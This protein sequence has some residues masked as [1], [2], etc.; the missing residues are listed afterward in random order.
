MEYKFKYSCAPVGK[1]KAIQFEVAS[2]EYIKNISVTQ[3]IEFGGKEI[4][5][6][7]TFVD[8]IDPATGKPNLGAINDPRMGNT[9]DL[10]HPGYFGHIEL[11]RPVYHIG[12]MKVV[13]DILRSVSY[14]TS[15]L[16][17]N[18]DVKRNRK[19]FNDIN[20]ILKTIK[21]CPITQNK[22]PVYSREGTKILADFGSGKQNI[23]TLEIYSILEKISD[24]DVKYL[25]LKTRPEYFLLTV[26]PVPPP[27]VRPSVYMNSSQKCDD[28]L[29]SNLNDIIK[30]NIALKTAT[31]KEENLEN[32][33]SNLEFLLQ[34]NINTLIDN[35]HPGQLPKLQRSGKPLKTI[36]ERLSGKD[37][38]V[39]GNLMGK[40]V[41][42]SARTVIT[43]DPNLSI[44]QVG[45]PY[46]IAINLTVPEI[47]NV[48]NKTRLQ[49]YVN[50]GPLT[51]PGAK[52]VTKDNGVKVDLKFAKNVD[53][54]LGWVIERHLMDNDYVIFN[55]QPSLH[56]MSIMGHKVK[57]LPGS[58]FRLNL[59]CT[60]PYNAD[61]D[62]DEMNL[63]VPQSLAAIAEVKHLMMVDKQIVSPQS[64]KP[65]ISIIQD[66]LLSSCKMTRR[67]VLITKDHL[68]NMLILIDNWDNVIPTP[69]IIMN[70]VEYWTGKQVYSIL[71]PK[72]L[73][74][75]N[76]KDPLNPHDNGLLIKSG[77]ILSGTIDKSVVG[78]SQG[79]LIH[80]LFNDYGPEITKIFLNQAQKISNYW[81][82]HNGFT[83][84]IGDGIV[85]PGIKKTIYNIIDDMKVKIKNEIDNNNNDIRITE[86]VINAEL[87]EAVSNAGKITEGSLT[88]NNNIKATVSSGS[89]GS[90]LNIS[91]IMAVVGQQNVEG[92]RIN[93]GF[94]H[95]TLP[96]FEKHDVGY[97]SRGFVEN[98]YMDGLNPLEFFFHAMAGREGLID[99]A[100]KSISGDTDILI[101]YNGETKVV[102]I[103]EWIDDYMDKRKEYV[104]RRPEQQDTEVID[105]LDTEEY[106][107]PTADKHGKTSWG[108]ITHMTRH[109][110]GELVYEVKTQSGR[111]VKVVESKSLLVYNNE[112]RIFEHK[113]TSQVNIGECVPVIESLTTP[114]IIHTYVDMSKYFPKTEYVH[115][116]EFNKAIEMMKYTMENTGLIGDKAGKKAIAEFGER[117]KIPKGWWAANNGK[118]FTTPYTKK[119]S[120]QRASIRSAPLKNGIIYP[121]I[122]PR[123]EDGAM[124]PDRFE[125]NNENGIFIGLFLAEGHARIEAGAVE[126]ANND[127]VIRDFVKKWFDKYNLKWSEEIR[128]VEGFNGNIWTS[129]TVKGYSTLFARF[130][131]K[132]LGHM[133]HGKYVPNEAFNA[134]EEFIT[135]LLNGYFSGDGTVRGNLISATSVS[136]IL[137]IGIQNLCSRIGVFC[138][139]QKVKPNKKFP[140]AYM[141]HILRI[142]GHWSKIF[143]SK[144]NMIERT[145]Q[146]GLEHIVLY[147]KVEKHINYDTQ[148]NVVLDPIISITKLDPCMY[149][150]VYDV[151]IPSTDNFTILNGITS[152]NTSEIGYLQRRLV[153]A[154]E[155]VCVKYNNTVQNNKGL[156]IQFLYGEDG[157]DATYL[158]NV[159][160]KFL[161]L[162]K[163]QL[164]EMYYNIPE[165]YE[166]IDNL[167]TFFINVC[168][169]RELYNAKLDDDYIPMPAN[170]GRI[171][172]CASTYSSKQ[173][174]FTDLEIFLKIK[175]LCSTIENMFSIADDIQFSEKH[176]SS[177]ANVLFR[178]Y[179]W[180]ELATLKIRHLTKEQIIYIIEEIELKYRKAIVHPGE[181]CGILAAQSIGEP[182]TQMTLNTFHYAGIASK[183]VTL[184]V[185]RLKELINITKKIKTPSLTMFENCEIDK[186]KENGQRRIVEQ[187]RSSLEH[188]SLQHIIE[189]VDIVKLSEFEEDQCIINYYYKLFDDINENSIALRFEFLAKEIEA[190]DTSVY[191]IC[192]LFNTIAYDYRIISSDD[193]SEN[194][195]IYII[196]PEYKGIADLKKMQ[197]LCMNLKVNGVEEIE[198]VF[199]RKINVNEYDNE[200]GHYKKEQWIFETEG[201][202]ILGSMEIPGIDHFKTTSNNIIE[203]YEIFGIEAARQTLLNEL[204]VVLLFDGS[205]VNY[206]HLALLVDSMTC[207]GYLTSITRHGIN[208][209]M[210]VGPL[211]KCSFEETLEVLTDAAIYNEVDNLKS[212]SDNIMLGKQVPAGTGVVDLYYSNNKPIYVPSKP[213]YDRFEY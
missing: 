125:L 135:G 20:R 89:K 102:K 37:G 77:Q 158:E 141:Q 213:N 46:N 24:E 25:G 187:I 35:Q 142:N 173:E 207:R 94:K 177:N 164:R 175:R 161:K 195:F 212:I 123:G 64:N 169:Y 171:I 211:T 186:L 72:T 127:P 6:G 116:T 19:N 139:L 57:V 148:E 206:R 162:N 39:R 129:S 192:K 200:N 29:T 122:G 117:I 58:T 48:F 180:S 119:A 98:S 78:K 166:I 42:F 43:A 155:D 80:V 91:Q 28:D 27:H 149:P 112:T 14:Y 62:G 65:V 157:L 60:S 70:N 30:A 86:D 196:A 1:V 23:S 170:I 121:Y 83:I 194:I 167:H 100:C 53:L 179:I 130:L 63:H 156:I 32:Y 118:T 124:L 202:N 201:A 3:K 13:L 61:F 36:K 107:M 90:I 114:P 133:S 145:K 138:T 5:K 17:L 15:T 96:H 54:K 69:A 172:T 185:P 31:E 199:S 198:K 154:L 68:M 34:Y 204:R 190:T 126:I 197:Y 18:K 101:M 208:R 174:Y 128:E 210:D 4:S 151:T 7:I 109:D 134:P 146:T 52:F 81:I 136:E 159:H 84:G 88:F 44:D 153:K 38:R 67:D 165:E 50:R 120:L 188:K 76:I 150:K 143:A 160:V 131:H 106:Y 49:E 41:D 21:V 51:H 115:G 103:G 71:V 144:V 59:A 105:F 75:D 184:G 137:L 140:N 9:T 2:P 87:N 111:S 183:N 12:F 93:Y 168:K 33:I 176:R 66:S 113:L 10:E 205:Y 189:N 191:N 85:D 40:R 104:E 22:L 182:A 79:S 56:K 178:A 108:R 11:V 110:P 193:N 45:V 73:S 47:V 16:L 152:K 147:G 95:R 82:K 92:R 74:I 163:E 8:S 26:L 209:I 99:T 132:F 55:R 181:M 97:E 203:I